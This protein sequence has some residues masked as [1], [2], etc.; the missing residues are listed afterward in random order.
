M[1]HYAVLVIGDNPEM[2]L[3]PFDENLSVEPYLMGEVTD[4]TKQRMLDYY[5]KLHNNKYTTFDECYA[6]N[7]DDWDGNRCQR[8]ENGVWYEYSTYNPNS[9]WDWY[10]LGGRWSGC[11]I[12]LKDGASGTIGFPSLVCE[13]KAGVD[14]A[15]KSDIDFDKINKKNFIPYAVL[16]EGEWISR[17]DM[18]WWGITLTDHYTD[19]EWEAKVWEL[20]DRTEDDTLFSFYDLHI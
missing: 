7:G 5:N 8:D 6:E 2:Q 4:M 14:Q 11:F 9:K 15:Y 12:K 17:G 19:E 1:S 3:E 18:G 10:S 16:Y 20:I 13:N